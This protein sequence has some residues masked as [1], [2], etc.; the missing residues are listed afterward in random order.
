M[1]YTYLEYNWE[2]PSPSHRLKEPF[3]RC[4]GRA[5]CTRTLLRSMHSGRE[6]HRPSRELFQ[7][8]KPSKI[9][10]HGSNPNVPEETTMDFGLPPPDSPRVPRWQD[11]HRRA[12][13]KDLVS[14]FTEGWLIYQSLRR[15]NPIC[16]TANSS[17][18]EEKLEVPFASP[19]EMRKVFP[20]Q[21]RHCLSKARDSESD[22]LAPSLGTLTYINYY[23]HKLHT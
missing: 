18:K 20:S 4:A 7:H 11:I 13:L 17:T 1:K 9:D 14:K 6:E 2:T 19:E 23:I 22:H 15:P 21:Y 16:E 8:P 5:G 12:E 10:R 3:Y